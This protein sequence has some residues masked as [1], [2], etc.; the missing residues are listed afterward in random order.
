M[1]N[2]IKPIYF[3]SDLHIGHDSIIKFCN[4]PT[5]VEQHDEWI[6][7]RVK[8]TVPDGAELYHLGDLFFR[9]KRSL[10]EK[11]AYLASF[12][13]KW[14]F[15]LGNHDNEVKLMQLARMLDNALYLGEYKRMKFNI[16]DYV[17]FHYPIQDWDKRYHDS[18]HI[19][20][21][22]HDTPIDP[23]IGNRFNACLDYTTPIS[24]EWIESNLIS[25]KSVESN[26]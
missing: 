6:R 2:S 4:R 5:T 14:R 8:S 21:H 22:I 3:T 16:H 18:I 10:E 13:V 25:V 19:H 23:V 9:D 20:G 24:S 26:K 1:S 12:K 11:A 15:I 7:D 17:L